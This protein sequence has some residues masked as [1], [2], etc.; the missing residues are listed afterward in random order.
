M[1]LLFDLLKKFG[2]SGDEQD[3]ANFILEY[4]DKRQRFW[5]VQPKVFFGEEFHDC[6]LLKFG[7]PRT[8]LFA[9][10]DTI[11]F[12]VRYENQLI[13]VGGPE[14][15]K[16]TELVGQDS[17]GKIHCKL[18][19][20]EDTPLHDFPRA[21]ERGTR[22]AFSQN[23]RIDEEFIQAAYLDNRLGLYTALQVCETI[24]DG[25]VVFTTYEEHGG[26]S[27]PFLLKFI[28]E[29]SPVRQALIADITWVT[30]GVLPHDGV[31]ISIR[32]KFIPRKKFID[33]VISLAEKSGIP[34][35]LEV[36]AYGGSDGREVQF[37]PYAID[38]VFVG[39]AEENVHTPD[40]KVSLKDLQS[41][42]EMHKYL[43]DSL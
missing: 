26:G 2:V 30:E 7:T 13:P 37:S 34:F 24:Q 15:I 33:K 23:A 41:M 25:W 6:I 27:M 39:A 38:W 10:M 35:Q 36:E 8:A 31:V 17:L 22:L 42:I 32:D 1:K 12:M 16:E 28:Q 4:I 29:T 11:G 21:I 9:H 5:N 18:I 3:T 14:F 40:E 20:D 19:G 43:M